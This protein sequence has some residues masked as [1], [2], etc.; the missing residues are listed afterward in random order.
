MSVHQ[1]PIMVYIVPPSSA[2]L[3]NCPQ[4]ESLNKKLTLSLLDQDGAVKAE[5]LSNPATEVSAPGL[6]ECLLTFA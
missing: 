6:F 4:F 2:L 3:E 1:A 5:C